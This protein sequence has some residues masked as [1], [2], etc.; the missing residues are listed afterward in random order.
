MVKN[1]QEV[2]IP[3]LETFISAELKAG[4][5][6]S[7]EVAYILYDTGSTDNTI[8]LTKKFFEKY[9]IKHC[10]IVQ[11]EF[12]DFATS[13]N[14]ALAV[15]RSTYP[16]STFILFPDAEW[17]MHGFDELLSFCREKVTEYTSQQVTP[18]SYYN[19][20]MQCKE[21]VSLTSR[22]L[23]TH[24]EVGFEGVVHECTTRYSD[25]AVPTTIHLE[26]GRSKFGADKSRNRWYRDRNL[27]MKDLQE[28]P[29]NSRSVFYLGLTEKW[30]G[31]NAIAY[32]YLQKR[33]NMP[34]FPEEDYYALY[35][36]AEVTEQLISEEPS[37][38]TWEEAL[39]HYLKAYSM[40]PHRA[41]PLVKIARHYLHEDNHP[42]SFLFARRACDLP[43][44]SAEAE[45]L[46]ILSEY[47]MFHRW[48][49]LS[50]S[51]WYVGEYEIGEVAAK[52]AIEAHPN[53]PHLYRN[54][55][56]YWERK[57]SL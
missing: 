42:L 27:L 12:I 46:P 3:T 6:D 32:H 13:R 25:Q 56:F 24:D 14:M 20:R 22:L 51:A 11:E 28:N 21:Y 8:P 5:K 53:S 57:K 4:K 19:I 26:I 30:L 10:Q 1:E 45:V 41:E 48:E 49:I 18:P 44:P 38:Y 9:G 37:K 54:L 17:Y 2:I 7:G 33:V 31:H 23:L 52:K 15:A 47:Y 35:N 34:T 29:T 36:L 39:G 50:R 40:R 16:E 43:L 55:S